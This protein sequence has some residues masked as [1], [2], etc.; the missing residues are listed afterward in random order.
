MKTLDEKEADATR[1]RLLEELKQKPWRFLL[2]P[3]EDGFFLLPL[4]HIGI[5][6]VSAAVAALLFA[7]MHYPMFRWRY[8]VPKGIAYFFVALYVLPHGIWSVIIAHLLVDLALLGLPLIFRMQGKPIWRR[9][10][11]L[12]R[13]E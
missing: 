13:T 6:P 10:I 4:L 3:A 8:C 2:I 5:S 7:A 9:L 1:E 11:R 12:L